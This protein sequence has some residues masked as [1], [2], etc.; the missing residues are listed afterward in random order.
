MQSVAVGASVCL[1]HAAPTNWHVAMGGPLVMVF[2]NEELM[3][4]FQDTQS[5][6]DMCCAVFCVLPWRPAQLISRGLVCFQG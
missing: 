6:L 2:A 1:V 4:W 3:F 5:R